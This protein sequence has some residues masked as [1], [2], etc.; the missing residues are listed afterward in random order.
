MTDR[1]GVQPLEEQNAM[2]ERHDAAQ[3]AWIASFLDRWL[4][5]AE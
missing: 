1:P 5:A 4:G 3:A 2:M